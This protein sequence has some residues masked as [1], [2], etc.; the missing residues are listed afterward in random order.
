MGGEPEGNVRLVGGTNVTEGRVEVFHNN[1]WGTV[2]D[3]SWSD[4]DAQVVCNQLF[5]GACLSATAH[6]SAYFG[7]GSGTIWLDNV[8][9]QGTESGL[10]QCSH[11]GWGNED[12]THGEDAG[13]QC[14]SCAAIGFSWGSPQYGQAS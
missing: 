7:A 1:E 12:C 5:G 2:C 13:V 14:N 9:C 3:D 8:A 10:D 11:A 6:S 4:V